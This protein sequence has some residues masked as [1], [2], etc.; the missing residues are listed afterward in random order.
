MNRYKM[1]SALLLLGATL[2]VNACSVFISTPRT[3]KIHIQGLD[4]K[5]YEYVVALDEPITKTNMDIRISKNYA[6][7]LDFEWLW[8]ASDDI[9]FGQKSTSDTD[10]DTVSP[11]TPW[12]L[13]KYRF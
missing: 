13:C 3:A 11:L 10:T 9:M 8:D 6:V 2:A 5:Y 4:N 12:M 7:Q 1:L